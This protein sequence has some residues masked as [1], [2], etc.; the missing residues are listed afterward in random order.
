M[1]WLQTD[2]RFIKGVETIGDELFGIERFI[3]P[4][5]DIE[6]VKKQITAD[7][8]FEKAMRI[9][10]AEEFPSLTYQRLGNI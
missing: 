2:P 9:K 6:Q 5:A 3:P 4:H 1:K 7:M 8:E 10:R